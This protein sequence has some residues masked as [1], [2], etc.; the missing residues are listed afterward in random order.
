MV[1][2]GSEQ[3]LLNELTR[4]EHAIKK[5]QKRI[6]EVAEKA[7]HSAPKRYVVD[8]PITVESTTARLA[9]V[10]RS[11]VIDRT[12]RAFRCRQIAGTSTVIGTLS[13]M[14]TAAKIS[15]PPAN[16][17]LSFMWQVRDTYTDRTW[18]N[19]FL[20][21]LALASGKNGPLELDQPAK[22]PP[23]TLLEVTVMPILTA[24]AVTF[25]MSAASEYSVQFS[26]IGDEIY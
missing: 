20:P 23:G 21:D 5:R 18:S 7:A 14:A 11:V 22:L 25:F 2:N 15:L 3:M 10:T 26:F 17:A 13:D 12:G 1:V 8:V 16:R 9:M 19:A 6:E 4:L 24:S